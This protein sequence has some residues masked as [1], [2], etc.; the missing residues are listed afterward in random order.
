MSVGRS[1]GR[2]IRRR[3]LG[4]SAARPQFVSVDHLAGGFAGVRLHAQLV[5]LNVS[6][7]HLAGGFAGEETAHLWYWLEVSVDHLAGGFAGRWLEIMPETPYSVG[8]SLGRRIRRQ[9]L[10]QVL[11]NEGVANHP[12]SVSLTESKDRRNLAYSN[13]INPPSTTAYEAAS[14]PGTPQR[15]RHARGG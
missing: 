3:S 5:A 13:H 8:R 7:D 4:R 2:R 1:L 12:A 14:I 6:V 10:P 9:P 11:A 15:Q